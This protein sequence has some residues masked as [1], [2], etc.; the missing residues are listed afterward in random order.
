ML[1]DKNMNDNYE[2]A[3]VD[4][5]N[6]AKKLH[7]GQ[8]R[9]DGSD[10]FNNHLAIVAKLTQDRANALSSLLL[11]SGGS[12][13]EFFVFEATCISYLHD[14]IEDGKISSEELG[15][16]LD[17]IINVHRLNFNRDMIKWLV[18]GVNLLKR[19]DGEL[20]ISHYIDRIIKSNRPE[21]ILVKQ[22]DL[23]HNISTLERDRKGLQT[24]DKYLVS[25]RLINDQM[26]KEI[27]HGANFRSKINLLNCLCGLNG[28]EENLREVNFILNNVQ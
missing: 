26:A 1:A 23:I 6:L 8:T 22:C 27:N 24:L 20:Y 28:N 7:Q 21:I 17:K 2:K 11:Y 12:L 13:R 15:E 18:S 25:L 4:V 3:L 16:S 10:Y 19:N 9:R 5:A 14:S